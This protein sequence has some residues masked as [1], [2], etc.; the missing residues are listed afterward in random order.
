MAA[1]DLV[2]VR[3]QVLEHTYIQTGIERELGRFMQE[4]IIANLPV[5]MEV[6]R[7]R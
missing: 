7:Y 5:V 6:I 4:Y 2:S 1:C 3:G